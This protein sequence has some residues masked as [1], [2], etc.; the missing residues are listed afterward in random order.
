MGK[1]KPEADARFASVR[2]DP[3][4]ARFPRQISKVKIDERFQGMFLAIVV[5]E[6]G[7]L[8]L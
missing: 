4:F 5:P 8:E 6:C 1:E 3:R 7:R 2:N